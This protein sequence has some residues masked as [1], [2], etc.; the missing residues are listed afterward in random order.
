MTLPVGRRLRIGVDIDGCCYDFP[1]AVRIWRHIKHGVPLEDM[2]EAE[3]WSFHKDQWNL[4]SAEFLSVCAEAVNAGFLY[5]QGPVFPDA[6]D[7]I[8]KLYQRHEIVV[9]T[10]RS[11]PGAE[12]ACRDATRHWLDKVGLPCHELHFS[13]DKTAFGVDTMVDVYGFDVR[14]ECFVGEFQVGVDFG[15]LVRFSEPA[16][17]LPAEAMGDE[18]PAQVPAD[19]GFGEAADRCRR[20]HTLDG[21]YSGEGA[22]R[23]LSQPP[24]CSGGEERNHR[25]LPCGLQTGV[26]LSVPYP[27]A[28]VFSG[29]DHQLPVVGRVGFDYAS[30]E[31]VGGA[32]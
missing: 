27:Q 17:L 31:V 32:H 4:S 30:A 26:E 28:A 8:S 10:D 3:S 23:V 12:E 2:P 15:Q 14:Y 21:P 24:C 20:T 22:S 13:A 25:G 29:L 1:N 18:K 5:W 11:L 9:I 7:V 6:L 19:V 16:E